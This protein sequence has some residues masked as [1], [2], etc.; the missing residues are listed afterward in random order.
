MTEYPDVA[1]LRHR[2]YVRALTSVLYV[3]GVLALVGVPV[4]AWVAPETSVEAL[5]PAQRAA[6]VFATV[7]VVGL[8]QYAPGQ[9]YVERVAERVVRGLRE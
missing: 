8:V 4:A 5:V 6:I 9:P 1:E 7:A 2:P 3:V